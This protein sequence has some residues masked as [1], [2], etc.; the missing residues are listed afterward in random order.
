MFLSKSQWENFLNFAMDHVL[1][2]FH[3]KGGYLFP[4]SGIKCVHFPWTFARRQV[5]VTG[6]RSLFQSE[7]CLVCF[8]WSPKL[9]IKNDLCPKRKDQREITKA[10]FFGSNFFQCKCFQYL[11]K[12]MGKD[13]SDANK[14]PLNARRKRSIPCNSRSVD[15]T[16]QLTHHWE[17]ECF[18]SYLC[19]YKLVRC[20]VLWSKSVAG[21]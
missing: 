19:S 4:A 17:E 18:S 1:A 5:M 20:V 14:F 6:T 3:P 15:W 11:Y 9:G 13:T 8:W 21:C 10:L 16:W 2:C 7:L 12:V